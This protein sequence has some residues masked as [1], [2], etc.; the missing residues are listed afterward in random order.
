L[1]L[2][3]SC[4]GLLGEE[5]FLRLLAAAG[6]QA[7]GLDASGRAVPRP[8]ELQVFAKTGAAEDHP[9]LA[10]QRESEYLKAIWLRVL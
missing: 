10:G 5:E 9:R 4:S 3:C 6:R 1:L 8:R 2:T 7:G